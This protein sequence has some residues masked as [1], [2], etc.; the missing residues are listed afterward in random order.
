MKLPRCLSRPA[1]ALLLAA[2]CPDAPA[3][4]HDITV[5]STIGTTNVV[6]MR[7]YVPDGVPVIRGILFYGNGAGGDDRSKANRAHYQAFADNIGFAIIATSKMDRYMRSAAEIGT[8]FNSWAPP[9]GGGD[10]RRLIEGMEQLVAASGHPEILNAPV[11]FWGFSGAGQMAYEYNAWKPERTIA[12]S[13]NKGR[14]YTTEIVA[15]Q[16]RRTP[17]IFFAG[18]NDPEP[19]RRQNIE[20]V[21]R[22]NKGAPGGALWAYML[23]QGKVHE[24]GDVDHVLL[25][26]FH[27]MIKLRYPAGETPVAGPVTLKDV[28]FATG[29][30]ADQTTWQTPNGMTA[31]A[32]VGVYAGDPVNPSWLPD[33]DTAFLFRA[34]SSWN[35]PLS[36]TTASQAYAAG[37]PVTITANTSAF[38]DWTKIEFYNGATKVGEV[39]AGNPAQL[40]LNVL[41]PAVYGFVALGY[42]ADGTVRT[43]NP[44][45]VVMRGGPGGP[46]P[47]DVWKH[48]VFGAQA[49]DARVSGDDADPDGDGVNNL[50]EFQAGTNPLD[51]PPPPPPP[52]RYPVFHHSIT[53]TQGSFDASA[54]LPGQVI[55][56]QAG[57]RGRLAITNLRG[58]AELPIII[59]NQGGLVSLSSGPSDEAIRIGNSEHFKLLGDGDPAIRYGIEVT[60][61][62]GTCVQITDKSTDF[63]VAFL[64]LHDAGYA[65]IM[66]KTDPR[67]DGTANRGTFTQRNVSFHDNY[68]HDVDGEGLYLG[69]SFYTGTTA[70]STALFPHD[71][72]GMRVYN[73]R[74]ERTGREGIQLGCVIQDCEVYNNVILNAGA[75]NEPDQN[76]G[77]QFGPGTTGRFYN[78]VIIG[79]PQNGFSLLGLGNNTVFN[80]VI[81]N[82]GVQGIFSDNRNRAAD[83]SMGTIAG[84]FIRILNNTFINVGQFGTRTANELSTHVFQNN[85]AVNMGSGLLDAGASITMNSSHNLV[86]A[87]PTGLGFVNAAAHDYRIAGASPARDTGTDLTALGVTFDAGGL[88]RPLGAAFDIGA[89]EAGGLSVVLAF[90]HPTGTGANDGT[91][92]A[93][94]IGGSAPYAFSWADGATGAA[95]TGLAPGAYTVTVTDAGGATQSASVTLLEPSPVVPIVV[96]ARVLPELANANDG[97][98]TLVLSGGAPPFTTTWAHGPATTTVT[99][100]TAGFYTYTVTDAVGTTTSAT[101]YVRDAG[102][103]IYR[104]NAGGNAEP[105]RVLNWSQDKEGAAAS[106]YLA[107]AGSLTTGSSTWSNA[108]NFT[109]APANL[110]GNRRYINTSANQL[111]YAFP[112]EPGH[113][114]INL[115]FNEVMTTYVVGTRVFDV[116]VEGELV[117]DNLDMVAAHGIDRPAQYTYVRN[118]IDGTINLTI[119]RGAGSAMISGIAIHRLSGPPSQV[120]TVQVASATF[121]YDGTAKTLQATT[122]PTG[123]ATSLTYNGNAAAPRDAAAYDVVATVTAPGYSGS[124]SGTLTITPA[125]A[126]LTLGNLAHTYD[127]GGKVAQVTTVPAGIEVGLTYDGGTAAPVN[128]G[129]YAV[130]ATV[131]DTNYAGSVAGTLVIAK[132]SAAVTLGG[133]SQVYDGSAKTATAATV[134]AG[135]PVTVAYPGRVGPPVD[136]GSYAVTA[137]VTEANY[138]GAAAGTLVI[139]KAAATVTLAGLNQ[140]YEGTPRIV[141]ATTAPAG[142]TVNTTYD[143]SATPPVYPGVFAVTASVDDA[144]HQAVAAG[145][146]TVRT[147]ALVRHAPVLNAHVDGSVQVLL[148]EGITFNGNAGLSGDLL[149]PGT[150]AVQLNGQPVYVGPRTGPGGASPS[151]YTVT[152]NGGATLR[153]LVSRIDPVAFPTVAA[154]PAPAGTRNVSINNAGQEPGD[155]A[156]LRNLTLNGNAGT[157]AVPAGTYGSFTANGSSVLVLGIA[158]AT[159]PAVYNLQAL[160]LNGSSRLQLAGP[161]ILTLAGGM[162]VNGSINADGDP[163]WLQLRV[164]SGDLTLN[165]NVTVNGHMMVPAGTV[166]LNNSTLNGSIVSDR[167]S[168]NGNAWLIDSALP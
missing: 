32:P 37:A 137:T 7:M 93:T 118:V 29:W 98:I 22:E 159:E 129:S 78:N 109:D 163:A 60:K 61:A 161:V 68:I 56:I 133:L 20:E 153:Y 95:R 87:T 67:A 85:L 79:A 107:S 57:V 54:V 111:R 43:S 115:Y 44:R 152:L 164:A 132:A 71:I 48:S 80:N 130:T 128:A 122:F 144:N 52:A 38:P 143:G 35:R 27:N 141:T 147:T 121:T 39:A 146:L 33:K 13:L 3:A 101:L 53:P 140:V 64:H 24:E 124:A 2:A 92:T 17:G 18:Q 5:N 102:T 99:G 148:G 51:T 23:E 142:L 120:A 113:Y 65:G 63:E 1:L 46:D 156:T 91:A 82:V 165:G 145:T 135:L 114:E 126:G 86:Q 103:P 73:N 45:A 26:F 105:D 49:G 112:V 77:A 117:L 74:T 139:G 41:P 58:T 168:L 158:G 31:I 136:A 131:T 127:G 28:P 40:T 4:I 62:T 155:F 8:N 116:S 36:I 30:L 47:L 125:A 50:A 151:N 167:L 134:P 12:Y 150:P 84:S 9:G 119:D 55:G 14:Y 16:G 66:S 10:G 166:T 157:V 42:K 83:P 72:I 34:L 97:R 96:N 88:A 25:R 69:S 108:N 149:V 75:L 6:Q 19:L 138:T 11:I 59:V 162:N 104:V 110:M 15:E 81:A 100:L 70:T 89:H 123:L 94:V 76:S 106:P 21:Y 154:P 160:A 90:T